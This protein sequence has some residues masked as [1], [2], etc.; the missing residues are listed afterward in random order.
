MERATEIQVEVA[1][2]LPEEQFLV[3]V[4]LPEGATVADA[5][6]ESGLQV[7]YPGLDPAA[8]GVGI[9]GRPCPLSQVLAAGDRVEVYRP[10]Q[11]DPKDRRRRR[12]RQPPK[13]R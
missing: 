5:I 13:E 12:A 8:A 10:L 7:R 2:A 3:E 11:I 6:R 1:Y 9:F 4:R